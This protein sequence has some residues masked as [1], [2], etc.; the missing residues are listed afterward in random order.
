MASDIQVVM[1]HTQ[2][3]RQGLLYAIQY[4]LFFFFKSSNPLI[5]EA[6]TNICKILSKFDLKKDWN[7]VSIIRI[8]ADYFPVD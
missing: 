1:D 4:F 6:E 2:H 5:W 7:D 3:S 8:V